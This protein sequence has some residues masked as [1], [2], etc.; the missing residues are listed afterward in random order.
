MAVNI[1]VSLKAISAV[2]HT[3]ILATVTVIKVPKIDP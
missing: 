3:P 2:P 1:V